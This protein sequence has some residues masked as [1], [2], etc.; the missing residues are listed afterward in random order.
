MRRTRNRPL[1][2]GRL[3]VLP[4]LGFGVAL[5]LLGALYLWL[6]VNPL[7]GGIGPAPAIGFAPEPWTEAAA[8]GGRFAFWFA[9]AATVCAVGLT[10]ALTVAE[11]KA[12]KP[13]PLP[14]ATA[15]KPQRPV[16]YTYN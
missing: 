14:R 5:S 11:V 4:A 13:A 1:P 7:T 9:M 8:T 16:E 2:A 10:T 15:R 6:A 3:E 12:S